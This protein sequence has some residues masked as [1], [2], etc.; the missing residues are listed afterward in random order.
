MSALSPV[1]SAGA[2]DSMPILPH[3]YFVIANVSKILG[4]FS[5]LVWLFAQ[6][7]QVL[8]NHLNES[9]SG[10]SLAFLICWISGDVTNLVG[11]LLSRAL[12]F[13]ICLA[14]Y[15]CF[16]D[17][18][19]SLQFWYYTR[20]YPKQR[21]HHNLLQS[22][23]MMRPVHSRGSGHHPH[24][25]RTNRF[26]SPGNELSLTRSHSSSRRYR[27]KRKSFILK[28][29]STSVLSSSFGKA[30]AM[31]LKVLSNTRGGSFDK[32]KSSMAALA[33]VLHLVVAK[34]A[35]FHY[36]GAFVG[37]VCGWIS[38]ALYLSSRSPQIWTNFKSKSTKGVSPFLF[39]FAMIGN[40]LY[41]VSIASDL[42]L[43]SKYDQHLGDVKFDEVFFAQ[44]PFIIGSSGTV[45]FD[46][47]L[48]FQFWLYQ[49]DPEYLPYMGHGDLFENNI[50]FNE[51]LKERYQ[52]RDH[53]KRKLHSSVVHF[54][55][56]DWYTNNYSHEFDEPDEYAGH[57]SFANQRHGI[58]QN[59]YGA[60]NNGY[61]T[62]N[63]G[64]GGHVHSKAHTERIMP[65]YINLAFS[66]PPP[67]HYIS[68]SSS[69]SHNIMHSKARKGISGTFSAI[70]RSFSHSSSMVKSPSIAS[71]HEESVG[72]PMGTGLLPH[73]VG[74]YSSVS[75]KMMNDSKI[76]FLPI[77]FLHNEFTQRSGGLSSDHP[78]TH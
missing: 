22:P 10:V 17:C 58:S 3:E 19:L 18:I 14:S 54:T 70:A 26:E 9:V 45:L 40:T 43:L 8:E 24:P 7:P 48:L 11:C 39:L 68:S 2:N 73:L 62:P 15:Y 23:N 59:G 72:S 36:N 51:S 64:N 50:N 49:K 6:L 61:E 77:D 66:I 76:P 41:T 28:L 4:I 60:I 56:P 25:S 34:A 52:K 38:S 74:T 33:P 71:S 5:L 42:Y 65:T 13:Q 32:I 30:N 46:A 75:K 27:S 21:I 57:Y 67:P 47:I 37:A 69:Q 78:Y 31:P 16:I 55:K 53:A 20:V 1:L 29:L 12:P 63:N 35:L 44:L